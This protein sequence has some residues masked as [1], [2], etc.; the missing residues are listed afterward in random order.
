MRKI[1]S[2][3]LFRQNLLISRLLTS[4]FVLVNGI[5]FNRSNGLMNNPNLM[6]GG[7]GG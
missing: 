3:L 5:V 7:V 4:V 1:C 2:G 6:G